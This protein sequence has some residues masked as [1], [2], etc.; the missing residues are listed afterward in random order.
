VPR[1]VSLSGT[2]HVE[3]AKLVRGDGSPLAAAGAIDVALSNFDFLAHSIDLSR[4]AVTAPTVNVRRD[5]KGAFEL[6]DAFRAPKAEATSSPRPASPSKPWRYSVA[7]ARIGNGTIR[8]SDASVTPRFDATLSN[9]DVTGAQIAST[10]PPGSVDVQFD[11]DGGTHFAVTSRVDIARTAASGHVALTKLDI[12]R[13]HPYYATMLDADVKRGTLDVAGDFDVATQAGATRMKLA[14]ASAALTDFDATMHGERNPFLRVEHLDIAGVAADVSKRDV[15]I[16]SL[17]WRNGALR[18]LRERDGTFAFERL[19]KPAPRDGDRPNADLRGTASGTRTDDAAWSFR[20]GSMSAERIA[21]DFEDRS[22]HPVVRVRL[23]DVR[24]AVTDIGSAPHHKS[25][26][27]ALA[28]VGAGGRLHLRG[29]FATDSPAADLRVDA[30]R[31]D[32]VPLRPYFEPRTNI[33]LTSGAV[34]AKG[35][36]SVASARNGT[37]TAKY[38]GDL[39][40]SDFATLDRPNSQELVR[41]KTLALTGI[42]ATR[43]P[44]DVAIGAIAMNG[45]Y[46]R[47]ILND[48]ATLNLQ[49]LLAAPQDAPA[50]AGQP[51]PPKT[52]AGVTTATLPPRNDNVALP[53]S[54]GRIAL[55]DGE[56]QY[57]DFFVKPN[58]TAHLTEVSGSVS[59]LSAT[60]A[61][62][63]ELTGRVEGSAPVDVRGTV[64]P[65]AS[66]LALDLTGKASD[67]DLP[68]LTPYSVKYAG[69]GIQKGK[70][71]LEVHYTIDNRKLAATNKLR[72]DQLTFGEHVDSATAT[73]LPVLLAVSLLKDRNGVINLDLPI[74]GTLD[75]PQFS[76]WHLLVQ[77]VK[78]LITK[79]IT[80]PFALLGSIAGGGGEQLAYVEFAPGR[81]E[82]SE[83]SRTK[84]ATLAKALSD[85]PGLKIDASG[86]AVGDVDRDGLKHAMLDR[87]V[88]AQKAKVL[89]ADGESAPAPDTLTIEPAEYPKLVSAVYR[90]TDLPNKPRNFLGIAKTLPT[91]EMEALLLASYRVDDAALTALASRRAE[92]VKRWFT[93]DGG[94]A[95]ERIFVVAAKL[96]ADGVKDSGSPARVDFAIR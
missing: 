83:A 96:G 75:D 16:E 95:A 84:L 2:A 36:V 8:F 11:A 74:E 34:A 93:G 46:A 45:F 89:A 13:L 72:L 15:A 91:A 52:A 18:L 10:G 40:F 17:R 73:K 3:A 69:Y 25:T 56:V 94:I 39:T 53:L 37:L 4:V 42:D 76:V 43:E 7:D 29:S 20:V 9:I 26:L 70:L 19:M 49:Q 28:R 81:A 14:A 50:G 77:I 47:V 41:F 21:T 65:F 61:G 51:A 57:S 59:A 31:I 32:L 80:A 88:R 1:G 23:P 66:E 27:D 60:Q 90:D 44:L 35:R 82:L 87:A 64:N 67:V 79:A 71:A 24:I 86:R 38:R 22:Q 92:A 62:T 6:A 58:Y 12:A 55:T 78:N 33:V 48:D 5:A 68:P 85:R 54:I 30:S 63:V